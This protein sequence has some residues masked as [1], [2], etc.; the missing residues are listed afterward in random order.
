M[1][2]YSHVCSFFRLFR[3][4]FAS[5][6]ASSVSILS[7]HCIHI[8][9][10]QLSKNVYTTHPSIWHHFQNVSVIF[11]RTDRFLLIFSVFWLLFAFDIV[12]PLH[13][14]RVHVTLRRWSWFTV[15][16]FIEKF[17]TWE[18]K[19]SR[20]IIII[21][22]QILNIVKEQ[23][24]MPKLIFFRNAQFKHCEQHKNYDI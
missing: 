24:S 4:R 20:K 21:I 22:I 2:D 13:C 12:M 8:I 19:N 16:N 10:F 7:S 5:A 15:A 1:L 23:K 3:Y 9:N 14:S 18:E 17:A 11:N 6:S